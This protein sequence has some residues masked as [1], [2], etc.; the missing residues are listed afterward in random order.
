MKWTI[1]VDTPTGYYGI[2]INLGSHGKQTQIDIM[3]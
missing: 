1:S 3:G 2:G